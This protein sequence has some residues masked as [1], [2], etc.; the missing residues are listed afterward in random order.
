MK[1]SS[2]CS[3]RC[4]W[5]V[6]FSCT[7]LDMAIFRLP[8]SKIRKGLL[9]GVRLDMYFLGFSTLKHLPYVVSFRKLRDRGLLQARL[10]AGRADVGKRE[11]VRATEQERK[12]IYQVV[13]GPKE[14][15]GKEGFL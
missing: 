15:S 8:P 9:P 12:H 11:S 13:G 7:Q 5:F 2:V 4:L 10:F 1:F 3:Y 6:L 14:P